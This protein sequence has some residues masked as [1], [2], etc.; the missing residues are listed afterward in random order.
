MGWTFWARVSFRRVPA[1]RSAKGRDLDGA[2]ETLLGE[3]EVD[4]RESGQFEVHDK[5]EDGLESELS[6][7][8]V[9][10]LLE[11][12]SSF[13]SQSGGPHLRSAFDGCR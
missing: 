6:G 13:G 11:V 1:Q 12:V 5:R 8:V 9:S 4:V 10:G 3:N 7:T 2:W